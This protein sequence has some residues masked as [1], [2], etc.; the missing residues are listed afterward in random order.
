MRLNVYANQTK[1]WKSEPDSPQNPPLL[2]SYGDGQQSLG[3]PQSV[4]KELA[5]H[6]CG[7]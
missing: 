2:G 6:S 7:Y 1:S 4:G 3:D 5:G